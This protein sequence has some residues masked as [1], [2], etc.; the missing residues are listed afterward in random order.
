MFFWEVCSNSGEF[1]EKMNYI[2]YRPTLFLIFNLSYNDQRELTQT[3][4]NIDRGQ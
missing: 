4:V 2:F 3:L 1:W